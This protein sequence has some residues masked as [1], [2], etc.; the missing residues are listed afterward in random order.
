MDNTTLKEE[1]VQYS[2]YIVRLQEKNNSFNS[3][4]V[5]KELFFTIKN[6]V[7]PYRSLPPQM[8]KVKCIETGQIFR[9]AYE[10]MNWVVKNGKTDNNNAYVN[11][12]SVCNKRRKTAYGYH[13]EFVN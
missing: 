10:A 12:K 3:Y 13:W 9:N 2:N 8:K 6:S 4:R 5:S 11:I 1:K 7:E